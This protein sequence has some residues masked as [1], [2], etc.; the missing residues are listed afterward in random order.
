MYLSQ[1][2]SDLRLQSEE[3]FGDNHQEAYSTVG[4]RVEG[5]FEV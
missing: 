4:G 3:N 1:G 5:K 2:T